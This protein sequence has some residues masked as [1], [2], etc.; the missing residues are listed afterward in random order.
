MRRAHVA[1]SRPPAYALLPAVRR[2]LWHFAVDRLFAA[3]TCARPVVRKDE[4]GRDRQ[5][6]SRVVCDL[7]VS[8]RPSSDLGCAGAQLAASP[9]RLPVVSCIQVEAPQSAPRVRHTH[10]RPHSTA[11]RDMY[12]LASCRGVSRCADVRRQRSAVLQVVATAGERCVQG[13]KG[14]GPAPSGV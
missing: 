5:T 3:R 8:G 1:D 7:S 10:R 14:Q 13:R 9:S 6:D 4:W 2:G 12:T 11:A